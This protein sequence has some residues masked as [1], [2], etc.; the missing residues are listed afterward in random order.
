MQIRRAVHDMSTVV[1]ERPSIAGMR[2]PWMPSLLAVLVA[3]S[4][5]V[6]AFLYGDQPV[7]GDAL[8]YY[9]Y[10]KLIATVGPEGV[11]QRDP[12]LRLPGPARRGHARRRPGR[13]GRPSWPTFVVQLGLLIGAAWIGARRIE[14]ALGRSGIGQLIFVVTVV[15]PFLLLYTVQLLTD[16]SAAVF[17]YLAV[18]LSLPQRRPESAARVTLLAACALL[19][20]GF[21]IMLRPTG[22]LVAPLVVGIWVPAPS[23]TATFPGPSCRSGCSPSGCRSCRKPGATRAPS[24]S[25]IRWSSVTARTGTTCSGG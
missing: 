4:I 8:G 18:V 5:A 16:L 19:C 22:L 17:V 23:S 15:N 1:G 3:I 14:G 7:F 12:D 13:R 11:R 25:P 24:A 20:A 2:L 6:A 21:A 10:G 9:D